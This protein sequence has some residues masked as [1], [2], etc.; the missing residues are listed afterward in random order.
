MESLDIIAG[1]PETVIPKLQ[2][3]LELMRPGIL[4]IWHNEGSVS[5]EDTMTSLRLLGTEVLPA[6]RQIGKKPTLFGPDEVVVGSR[7]L[8]ASANR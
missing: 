7:P 6:L 8:P 4:T 1:S 2:K 5:H 3:S